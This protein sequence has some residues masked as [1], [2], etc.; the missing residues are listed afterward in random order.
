VTDIL[1]KVTAL[2]PNFLLHKPNRDARH[3]DT[4]KHDLEVEN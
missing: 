4:T 1:F 3:T 2:I